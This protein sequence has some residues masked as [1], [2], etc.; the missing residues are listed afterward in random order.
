MRCGAILRNFKETSWRFRVLL[1]IGSKNEHV[2]QMIVV[3]IISVKYI[4]F[5][6]VTAAAIK[7]MTINHSSLQLVVIL[8]ALSAA[9]QVFYP[10]R[11]LVSSSVKR[12]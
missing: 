5:G 3:C 4:V 12:V 6:L 1:C 2:L 10:L 8:G 7:I 11:D 9:G